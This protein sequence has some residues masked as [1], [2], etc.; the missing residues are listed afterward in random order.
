MVAVVGCFEK[1]PIVHLS[2][3]LTR[4]GA[5]G[6]RGPCLLRCHSFCSQNGIRLDGSY[7][8]EQMLQSAIDIKVYSVGPN[9]V[10]AEVWHLFGPDYITSKGDF[11]LIS[12][13]VN[14]LRWTASSSAIRMEKR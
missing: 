4:F 12:R 7:V 13:L 1:G 5:L 14:L 11:H 10:Y 3:S 2:F 9:Y 6:C 8:Y